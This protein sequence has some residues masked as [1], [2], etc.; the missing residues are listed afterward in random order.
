MPVNFVSFFDVLRFANWLHNGQP[1]GAQDTTTTE[2]GTYDMTLIPN[3]VRK[4]GA[5]VF[6]PTE[7]EWYKAA[8]FNGTGYFDYPAGTS[9]QTSGA[10]PGPTPNT[11]NCCFAVND[12]TAVGGYTASASPYG[13]FDQ[14]GN[15]WEWNEAAIGSARGVR[16]GRFA[17]GAGL[18][19]AAYRGAEGPTVE[20]LAFGFRV[21]S[22]VPAAPV[23]SLG[24]IGLLLVAAGLLGFGAYR[25]G[26]G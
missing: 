6:L 26:R 13:T 11:A 7:D 16:S 12:L 9:A 2:D 14:G 21:A 23:P 20:R 10:V 22:R 4:P 8:Y 18:L 24:P 3:V 17:D 25:R 1:T 19:A 15:V 5:Q